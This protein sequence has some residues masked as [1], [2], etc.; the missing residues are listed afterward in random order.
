MRVI[1]SVICLSAAAMVA[2]G[3]EQRVRLPAESQ[4]DASTTL[5]HDFGRVR[6]GAQLSYTFTVDNKQETPLRIMKALATCGCTVAEL[7]EGV[8]IPPGQSL[9]V[10][11][12]VDM[13][14]KSG[15]VVQR[16]ILETDPEPESVKLVLKG[17]VQD[18]YP[19]LID[20]GAVL[21]DACP[22]QRFTLS[23]WPGQP[24]IKCL[25]VR[26]DPAIVHVETIPSADAPGK[27]DVVVSLAPLAPGT[28]VDETVRLLT[29][30]AEIPD[31]T[32]RV[33]AQIRPLLE[34][35]ESRVVFGAVTPGAEAAKTVELTAPYG[36]TLSSVGL[37]WAQKEAL[38]VIQ[39]PLDGV[40]R[41]ALD[42]T[43]KLEPTTPLGLWKDTLL[44]TAGPNQGAVDLFAV[45]QA[46]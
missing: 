33:V 1:L 45:V 26:V 9:E 11:V 17:Q 40:G 44:I 6:Q 35:S 36:D 28:N 42:L 7:E 23:P 15:D 2:A 41:L 43:L 32:V 31:K 10:P 16:V 39:R 20:F 34:I 21:K 13:R 46:H 5:V 25:Q 14:N 18:E 37:E 4:G 38:R 12:K 29:N 3:E 30:D 24:P 19:A 27:V 8:L 22:S